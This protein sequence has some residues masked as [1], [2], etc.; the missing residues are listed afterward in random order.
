MG[1]EVVYIEDSDDDVN[2][3]IC[4]WNLFPPPGRFHLNLYMGCRH[5]IQVGFL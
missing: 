3:T 2:A 5:I 4:I 1:D